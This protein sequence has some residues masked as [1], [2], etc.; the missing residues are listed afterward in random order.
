M[1]EEFKQNNTENTNN[2][3]DKQ[4]AQTPLSLLKNYVS[5]NKKIVISTIAA[6][7]LVAAGGILAVNS[8]QIPGLGN[9]SDGKVVARVNGEEITKTELDSYS[10]QL[11]SQQQAAQVPEDELRQRALDQLVNQEVLSQ[12]ARNSGVSAGEQEVQDRIDQISEQ[13]QD[14]SQFQDRLAQNGIT[15]EDLRSDIRNQIMIQKYLDQQI[16]DEQ[17]NPTDQEIEQAYQNL[18]DQSGNLPPLEELRSQLEQQ[19]KSQKRNE[20]AMNIIEELKEKSEIE[21]L[22]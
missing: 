4:A 7:F 12:E 11:K 3:Q 15:E 17:T 16:T 6:L 18:S 20:L 10:Q 19:V 5:G 9:S 1:E 8:G 14:D 13:F 2:N 21:I 22:I